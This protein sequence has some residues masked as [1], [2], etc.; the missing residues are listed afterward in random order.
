MIVNPDKFQAIIIKKNCRIKD[1]YALNINSQTTNFENCVKR[2]GIEI[3]N[4]QY[5]LTNIFLLFTKKQAIN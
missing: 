4:T 3:D 1:L 5:L 2:L